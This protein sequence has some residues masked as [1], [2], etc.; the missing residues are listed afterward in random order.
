MELSHRSS[1]FISLA[2]RS[3]A[4]LRE[5][6]KIPQEYAV[7]FLQGGAQTQFSMV[8]LNLLTE[9]AV[10]DYI[11]SGYWSQL[12]IREGRRYGQVNIA[13]S[14]AEH[15]F[16]SIPKPG[17]WSLNPQASYVHY[18]ANETITGLEFHWVPEVGEV[19]LVADMSSTILSRP[20]DVTRYGLIYA[21]AQKNI[22]PAG[23]TVVIVRRD[24]FG[25]TAQ[26]APRLMS[27]EKQDAAASMMNTVPTFNWYVISLVLE[28]LI[29]QGGV[30]AM[31]VVNQRKADKLYACIDHSE[32]FYVN[33]VAHD[34]RSRMNVTFNL[35]DARLEK[36]FVEETEQEGM[37]GLKG[38]RAVGGIR[39]SIYNAVPE[40]GVDFLIAFMEDFK[41]R[42][43]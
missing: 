18:T 10:A 43:G 40:S 5:L 15:D 19:P 31:A 32:G 25:R 11:D 23:I 30:A 4:D 2:E 12:A 6:L 7:L 1:K 35:S 27:Y 29:Q 21:G 9:N 33:T 14:G 3:Q 39:A 42:H 8:P 36:M 37:I 22:G 28:W 38:H 13:A 17:E 24:L 20:L 34:C 26:F 16:M 41:R